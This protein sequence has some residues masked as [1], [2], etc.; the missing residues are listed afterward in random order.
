MSNE[1]KNHLL[2]E[3]AKLIVE[4]GVNLQEAE[5]LLIS[6]PV[7]CV[8]F[9]RRLQRLAL[10]KGAKDVMVQWTDSSLS[11]NRFELLSEEQ[12]LAGIDESFSLKE[13]L[14]ATVNKKAALIA[15]TSPIS[16][17][18]E[19]LDAQLMAKVGRKGN[20]LLK[21]ARQLQM[22]NHVKWCVCA[23][24]NEVWAKQVFP[25]LPVEEAYEKLLENIYKCCRVGEDKPAT[26]LQKENSAL[27]AKRSQIINEHQFEALHFTTGLG[28]DLT[29]GLPK[30]YRF[31]GGAEESSANCVF[32]ANIPTLEV[33]SAPHALKVNGRVVASKPLDHAGHII[34]GIDITFKDGKA[35]EYTASKNAQS[36]KELIET[37]ETSGYLGEVALVP[38]SSPISQTGL[39]FFN[40][41]FDENASCHLALG[42]AYPI[43]VENGAE[44][45]PDELKATGLNLST[46]HVD[47]MFGTADL[48]CYGIKENGERVCIMDK[49]EFVI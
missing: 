39:L 35:V 9:G 16:G 32:Q 49:G 33:F 24:P 4:V 47:F 8:E 26:E 11:K 20:E 46:V 6:C 48:A 41:L 13:R 19:G 43:C 38:H 14:D 2:T 27:L 17:I 18:F 23:Y 37:D 30:N 42:M 7:E 12:L 28:T 3:Y 21:E 15:V 22:A 25:E 34:E 36:L 5:Y 44:M 45:T 40:T 31:A 1:R 29:V 10:E